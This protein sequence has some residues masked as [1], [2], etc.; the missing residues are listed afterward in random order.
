MTPTDATTPLA[1][2]NLRSILHNGV[3]TAVTWDPV[4][5]NSPITY[6]VRVDGNVVSSTTGTRVD[7]L[8]L[9]FA[10]GYIQPGSTHT[11]TVDALEATNHLSPPSNSVTVTFPR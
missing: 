2:A 11:L 9:L 5:D 10:L 3:V 1:P 7:L 8:D 4:T 6:R